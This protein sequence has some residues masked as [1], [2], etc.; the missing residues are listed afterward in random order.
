MH[1]ISASGSLSLFPSLS[2]GVRKSLVCRQDYVKSDDD[3]DG[4]KA[5]LQQ[6]CRNHGIKEIGMCRS[7]IHKVD[8]GSRYIG[9]PY[10]WYIPHEKSLYILLAEIPISD[11]ITD[12]LDLI[13]R[14]MT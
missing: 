1:V 6:Y 10:C 8:I 3:A 5:R 14:T 12:Y 4:T 7:K 11:L 9:D 2:F 13:Q